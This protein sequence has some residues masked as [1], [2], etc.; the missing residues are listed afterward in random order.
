MPDVVRLETS[1]DGIARL[2]LNRPQARNALTWEAMG[3]FAEAV[4]KAHAISNLRGLVV[5][6]EGGSFCAGGDLYELDA[7]PTRADGARLSAVMA[8]AL[9]RLEALPFPTVAAIEGP[10]LGGG[11]EIALAC[12]LRVMATG[13]TLGMMHVRLGIAPA[14]GGGQRLLRLVGYARSMEFLT[15]GR[16][17]TA[18]AAQE[19]GLSNLSVPRGES[20]E[21]ALDLA[22]VIAANDPSAVRAVKRFLQAGLTRPPGEAAQAERDEFP[23]L[24]SSTPHLEASASFVA[25]RNHKPHEA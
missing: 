22:R 8:A 10:A 3:L 24:W 14:W 23:A 4:E 1:S 18:E 5:T 15:A 9:D 17:L 7:F 12:D 21:Q 19:A 6:G 11:A 20:L 16:V 25:R 13:A 2:V